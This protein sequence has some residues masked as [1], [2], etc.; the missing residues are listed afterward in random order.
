MDDDISLIGKRRR[1]IDTSPPK[2]IIKKTALA[3]KKD[4][5][6]GVGTYGCAIYPAKSCD[7]S[8]KQL[9]NY[10]AKV[11]YDE[12]GYN[13]ELNENDIIKELDPSSKFTLLSGMENDS[14]KIGKIYDFTDCNN[15]EQWGEPEEYYQIIYKMGGKDLENIMNDETNTLFKHDDPK[16]TFS[17]VR[18]LNA[19]RSIFEGFNSRDWQQA[20]KAHS[21]I[22]GMN[23]TVTEDGKANLIDF[24]LMM[25]CNDIYS[26]KARVDTYE[27]YMYWPPEFSAYWYLNNIIKSSFGLNERLNI[28][29][30]ISKLNELNINFQ[31][32]KPAKENIE[33]I[34]L[35]CPSQY[36]SYY[37]TDELLNFFRR[38]VDK[39]LIRKDIFD[40]LDFTSSYH[41]DQIDK[42][43]TSTLNLL[44]QLLTELEDKQME[45]TMTFMRRSITKA[46]KRFTNYGRIM[47]SF[48]NV[49]NLLKSIFIKQCGKIDIYMTGLAML[50]GL[51][52]AVK[53]GALLIDNRFNTVINYINNLINFNIKERY[54]K[55][56]A[57]DGLNKLINEMNIIE[58][59][60]VMTLKGGGF[61][62]KIKFVHGINGKK[63]NRKSKSKKNK[64]TKRK[65]KYLNK[66]K[67]KNKNNKKSLKR[68]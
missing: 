29:N 63:Q 51:L 32:S 7:P 21:D 41:I 15:Q 36:E 49:N 1:I 31:T 37:V 43:W 27:Q 20:S 61:V 12:N 52:S 5:V 6:L 25:N 14:C 26:K 3:R 56:E 64:Q 16:L 9:E 55:Q 4:K 47:L 8:H 33:E 39:R 60:D 68:K 35:K 58:K 30:I 23:I 46:T 19:F 44:T 59:I 17:Y 48:N 13:D 53:V 24:G 54:T 40:V 50:A 57:L 45:R 65:N 22:K 34:I 28:G 66:N 2:K 38:L 11:F 42:L 10:V 62:R 18:Y 67:N